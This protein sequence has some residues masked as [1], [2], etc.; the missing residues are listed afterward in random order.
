MKFDEI[1]LEGK[2]V[3]LEPLTEKHKEGLCEAIRDGD[4]WNLH[5]TLVPHPSDIDS[6]INT[7]RE[8]RESG[9]GLCFATINKDNNQIVGSTRFMKANI[10]NQRVEI[11]FTFLSKKAQ[12][13]RMNTE[14]KMLM[15][16][17]AFEQMQFNRVELLTDYLNTKS[18]NAILRLGAKEE[19]L[20]RSHMVMP[21][22]RI[23]DSVIFSII[24]GE[25]PGIKQHL[26]FKINE[27][28]T[29]ST[30]GM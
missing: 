2:Y 22:G 30:T 9:D 10:P 1:T 24:K 7:A 13:T 15:L 20:L 19:G 17:H 4:L 26:A 23:R 29:V 8:V 12:K 14:A 3:K 18:R 21:D 6:F 25:W 28:K 5:V 11:G 27:Q 16:S